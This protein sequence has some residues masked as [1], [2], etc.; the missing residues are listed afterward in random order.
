M[1]KN[2]LMKKEL[3]MS[4]PLYTYLNKM[5]LQRGKSRTLIEAA[6]T[7]FDECKTPDIFWAE[8]INTACHTINRFY[9]HKY[10]GK[11]PYEIITGNKPKVH[12]LE[13]LGAS[14]S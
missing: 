14:V 1:V 13:F 4:S 7:M 10:L 5:V 6:R 11:T 2:F 3:S 8:A 9:L 12:Y